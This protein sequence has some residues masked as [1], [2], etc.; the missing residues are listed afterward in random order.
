MTDTEKELDSLRT[1]MLTVKILED[2]KNTGRRLKPMPFTLL[3][4]INTYEAA[5]GPLSREK[6]LDS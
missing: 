5:Y 3:G 4:Y 6:E 2:A 1:F